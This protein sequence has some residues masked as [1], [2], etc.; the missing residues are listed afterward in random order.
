ML[1]DE[2]FNSVDNRTA[3]TLLDV[4]AEWHAAGKTLV[5]VVHDLD[6]TR[7]H[8]PQALLLAR[9]VVAWGDCAEALQ[10]DNLKRAQ[11]IVDHWHNEAEWCAHP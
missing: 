2:P 8:F 5:T 3:G 10:P 6:L 1:L 11:E 7:R 9:E 4:L